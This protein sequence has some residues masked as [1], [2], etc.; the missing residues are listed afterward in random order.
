M[1]N[2]INN[3]LI[4][5]IHNNIISYLQAKDRHIYTYISKQNYEYMK[6]YRY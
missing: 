5:N 1:I 3:I 4:L 6:D 2:N